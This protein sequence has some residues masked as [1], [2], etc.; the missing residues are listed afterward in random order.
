MT[1]Q[2]KLT[3]E[4][5]KNPAKTKRP[6]WPTSKVGVIGVGA[7]LMYI[8]FFFGPL[9]MIFEP[10][11]S[12]SKWFFVSFNIG[13][14]LTALVCLM[15]ARFNKKDKAL[16]IIISLAFVGFIAGFGVLFVLAELLFPHP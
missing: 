5:K 8:L 7:S 11:I 16:S 14:T 3:E 12:F 6:F 15:L 4:V 13:L 2:D 10:L 9:G 1:E